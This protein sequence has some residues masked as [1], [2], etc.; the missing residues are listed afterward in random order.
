M[1]NDWQQFL[2]EKLTGKSSADTLKAENTV[3]S[4]LPGCRQLWQILS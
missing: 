2:D 4:A 3:L 1:N